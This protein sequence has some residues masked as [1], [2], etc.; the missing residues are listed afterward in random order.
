MSL[1][2]M[3]PKQLCF[4][5][6][7]IKPRASPRRANATPT[8]VPLIVTA[9]TDIWCSWYQQVPSVVCVHVCLS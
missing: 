9:Y 8:K 7:V 3:S 2:Q 5:V 6:H 1:V 4:V